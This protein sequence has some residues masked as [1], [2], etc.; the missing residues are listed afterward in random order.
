MNTTKKPAAD[1]SA[2]LARKVDELN[3]PTM[4]RHIF[5][6]AD[7]TE[8][9]CSQKE[10]SL[11][12]WSYLKKRLDE[13]GLVGEGGIYRTKANCLRICQQGPVA[14]VYPDGVWYRGCTPEVLERIIQ[15]HLVGGA[16]VEEFVI[17]TNPLSVS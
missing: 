16:P 17:A 1:R 6:C 11:A 2:F 10:A 15:E 7:Q 3:I 14:V 9:K 4:R 13:L 12:S 8:P 5:L